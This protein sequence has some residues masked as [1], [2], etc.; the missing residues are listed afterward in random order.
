M[1]IAFQ[2][3]EHGFAWLWSFKKVRIGILDR[4][5]HNTLDTE[6]ENQMC[7]I[8]IQIIIKAVPFFYDP[9]TLYRGGGYYIFRTEHLSVS[10]KI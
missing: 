8:Q 10:Y 3:F 4:R 9:L 5:L 2:T 7:H 1:Y 6:E